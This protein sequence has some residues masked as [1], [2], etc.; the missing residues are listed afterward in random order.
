M[1]SLQTTFCFFTCINYLNSEAVVPFSDTFWLNWTHHAIS[2]SVAESRY[3]LAG[4]FNS[5]A[6]IRDDPTFQEPP[7]EIN[8]QLNVWETPEVEWLINRVLLWSGS[9]VEPSLSSR[10]ETS[11]Y[12]A[13]LSSLWTGYRVICSLL[14]NCPQSLTLHWDEEKQQIS[15]GA[16]KQASIQTCL[17]E[18][19]FKSGLTS[20]VRTMW[21]HRLFPG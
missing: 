16:S 6:P 21:C 12:S 5:S 17:L 2:G 20:T 7:E 13:A 9:R 3:P 1:E 14:I 15:V 18:T 11:H 10:W 8:T 19:R 4:L